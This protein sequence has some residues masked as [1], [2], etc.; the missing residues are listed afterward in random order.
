[1]LAQPPT[2]GTPVLA[3]MAA[4]PVA[5]A[6]AVAVE[7][8]DELDDDAVAADVDA[9]RGDVVSGATAVTAATEAGDGGMRLAGRSPCAVAWGGVAVVEADML[10]PA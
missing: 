9:A 4:V 2:D 5:V 1:M 8:D 7:L 6:V 10:D 3:A